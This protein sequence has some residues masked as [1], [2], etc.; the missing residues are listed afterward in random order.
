MHQAVYKSKGARSLSRIPERPPFYPCTRGPSRSLLSPIRKQG[1]HRLA[2]DFLK[3]HLEMICYGVRRTI[4][5]RLNNHLQASRAPLRMV[6]TSSSPPSGSMPPSR[7]PPAPT[8]A[9]SSAQPAASQPFSTSSSTQ[10]TS[11]AEQV[12]S[13]PPEIAIQPAKIVRS[14]VIAGTELIGLAYL[15]AE[16]KIFAKEDDEYPDWLWTLLDDGK[17]DAAGVDVACK[18][19][20]GNPLFRVLLN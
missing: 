14:S 11:D 6:A 3:P 2:V 8:P 10:S 20:T 18:S 13:P 15:K 5:T 19:A 4:L 17:Q 12:Q 7:N 1:N 16:P 9:T